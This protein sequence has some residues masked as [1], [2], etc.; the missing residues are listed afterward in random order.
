MEDC[1]I[2]LRELRSE[3]SPTQQGWGKPDRYQGERYSSPAGSAICTSKPTTAQRRH[4][5]GRPAKIGH[6]SAWPTVVPS[7]REDE[8]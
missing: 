5:L 1:E 6:R 7:I 8:A 2:R 4:K 3:F